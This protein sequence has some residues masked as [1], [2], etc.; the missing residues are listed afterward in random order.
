MA[1]SLISAFPMITLSKIN[2]K[3]TTLVSKKIFIFNNLNIFNFKE[4]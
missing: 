1:L 3:I 2:S 4:A